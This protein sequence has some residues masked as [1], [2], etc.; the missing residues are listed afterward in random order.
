[1]RYYINKATGELYKAK[2]YFQAVRYFKADGKE[3][4]YKVALKDVHL[5]K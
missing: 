1:M 5:Y 3:L 4:H 2:N